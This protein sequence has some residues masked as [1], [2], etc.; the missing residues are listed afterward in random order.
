MLLQYKSDFIVTFKFLDEAL[1]YTRR[2]ACQ[3]PRCVVSV[4]VSLTLFR[5]ASSSFW[6]EAE[7]MVLAKEHGGPDAHR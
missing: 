6:V 4:N 7:T 1:G 5:E 2:R 3:E